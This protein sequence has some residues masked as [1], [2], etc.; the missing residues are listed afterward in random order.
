LREGLSRFSPLLTPRLLMSAR[1]HAM[2]SL[3]QFCLPRAVTQNA[4]TT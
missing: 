2:L 1:P 4:A 3:M